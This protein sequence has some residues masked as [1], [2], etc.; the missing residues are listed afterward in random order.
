MEFAL[1]Q[2]PPQ[3]LTGVKM[4]I[5][6]ILALWEEFAECGACATL[7]NGNDL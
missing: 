7:L 1:S 6:K 5:L 3:S 4:P 2:C